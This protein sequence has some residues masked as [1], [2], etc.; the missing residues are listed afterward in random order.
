MADPRTQGAGNG[1][2][3]PRVRAVECEGRLELRVG[4]VV[5]SV[6]VTGPELERGY[7]PAM[8]PEERPRSALLLGLGGG[9]VAQLLTLR[10]GPL[11]IVG[12]EADD[13][14]LDLARERFRLG[15]LANLRVVRQDAYAYVATAKERF[16]YIAV[17]LFEAGQVPRGVTATPF[18][19]QVKQL[20]TPEGL[21]A[22]N[23]AR[24]RRAAGRVH[25]LARVFR[26][27]RQVFV[28]FN[29]VVHCRQ[30]VRTRR[31]EQD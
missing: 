4:D 20:L 7:W 19:R 13:E 27:E 2:G 21:V 10:F 16:D 9:T 14:V 30:P 22:F 25:R 3:T 18:L 1:E 17:D 6:L 8:L 31:A 15:E 5:Q 28:G 12:V 23:L 29:L 24:D 11:P 26:V